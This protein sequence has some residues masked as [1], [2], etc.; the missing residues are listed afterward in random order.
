MISPGAMQLMVAISETAIGMG[1]KVYGD[2]VSDARK[3][4]LLR[5]YGVQLAE[6]AAPVMEEQEGGFGE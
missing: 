6:G 5:E 3:A 4:A 2:E 1:I